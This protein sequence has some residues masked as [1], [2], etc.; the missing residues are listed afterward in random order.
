MKHRSNIA[1][2]ITLAV[3]AIVFFCLNLFVPYYDDDVWYSLR[4]IP[5]ETVAPITQFS[6]ILVSQYHHY[7][8]ENS[9]AIIHITL[10]SLLA[11][12]P[13]W[14]FDI[15]NTLMFLLLLWCMAR[16]TQH[17]DMSVIP[18]ALLLSVAGIYWLLPDMD[19][20]FYWAAGSLNYM[21]TSVATLL[22]LLLWTRIVQAH[23]PINASSFLYAAIAFGCAF[24]HEAFALPVGMAILLYMLW[25]YRKIGFNT[26]TITAIAYGM[27]CVAIL[28]APG[29]ENK[30]QY[31]E[32]AS[33]RDY[34]SL[35]IVTLRNL[36]VIPLCIVVAAVSMCRKSWR[37]NLLDFLKKNYLLLI[38]TI[39]SFLFVVIVRAGSATLR[40]YYATEFFALLLLLSYL[41]RALN[42]DRYRY[43]SIALASLLAI[44]AAVVL[45]YAHRVGTQHHALF[46]EY[47]ADTDGNIYLPAEQTP[48]IARRWVMN[49]QEYYYKAPEA[50][51]RSFVIPIAGLKDTLTIPTPLIDR[52]PDRS[53]K[54]YNKYIQIIPAELQE[55]LENP[56]SYF[57]PTHKIP[58]DN[59]F[60]G[61]HDGKYIITPLDSLQSHDTWLWQYSVASWREPS[62]SFMGFV[63]RVIAPESF[64]IYET[65]Q[66]PDT[67]TLP[68]H[69]SYVIIAKP[70]YRTVIGVE[71]GI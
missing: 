12:L 65:A 70:A 30:S 22:F 2:I 7:M 3:V 42:I 4:Y 48:H 6:D 34:I 46:N 66:Y 40:S 61:A 69:E 27:G 44:W 35:L 57:T 52:N 36:R 19:Y 55:A 24:S 13:D 23:K 41:H 47:A 25:H 33:A 43:T 58:G 28:I 21:W 59:P 63:K 38:I 62:A 15:V 53:Y 67:I 20:L 50:E 60:Y 51:W 64:P 71:R 32:Y 8:G 45:P 18:L 26:T 31:I 56:Q 5:G 17:S 68:S 9:R 1:I 14:G 10:Q 29:L 11:V 54:L 39:V 37:M 49:L 16:Y